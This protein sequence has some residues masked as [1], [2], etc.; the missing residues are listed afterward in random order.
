MKL[1]ELEIPAWTG[2]HKTVVNFKDFQVIELDL[3][4][5]KIGESGC[6][7]LL[8]KD[9]DDNIIWFA[10]RPIGRVYG[11][12]NNFEYVHSALKGWYGG[13][14][15]LEIDPETGRILKQQFVK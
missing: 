2:K 12:F 5:K 10:E 14:I 4:V 7:N 13:S 3:D 8:A 6:S 9:N 11:W 1:Q 15:L